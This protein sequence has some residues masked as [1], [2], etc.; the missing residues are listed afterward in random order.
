M[1]PRIRAPAD[2]DAGAAHLMRVCPVWA[3]EL[4]ALLPL[5]L[6]LRADGFAAICDAVVS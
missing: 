5:P 1:T 6:R 2:L 4:P 3:R